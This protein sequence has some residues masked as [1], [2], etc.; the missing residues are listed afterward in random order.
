MSVNAAPPNTNPWQAN[1]GNTIRS[2]VFSTQRVNVRYLDSE[3][4]NLEN[5]LPSGLKA[6]SYTWKHSTPSESGDIV[7]FQ[8]ID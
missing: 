1:P 6:F 7:E 5:Y 3:N 4:I 8:L 2:P